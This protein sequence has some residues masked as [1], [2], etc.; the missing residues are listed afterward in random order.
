MKLIFLCCIFLLLA[1]PIFCD[2]ALYEQ[3]TQAVVRIEEHQSVC[4][5]GRDWSIEKN[6]TIGS[7][8][9]IRDRLAGENNQGV[10]RYFIVTARHVVEN[11]GDLFA[12]I[13][14]SPNSNEKAILILPK[15]MWVFHPEPIQ[16]GKFPIDVAVMHIKSNEF[17]KSFLHCD[18]KENPEG[19]GVNQITKKPYKNQVIESPNVIDRGIFFGFPARDVASEKVE[20][21]ARSGIVA[22]TAPQPSLT[23]NGQKV[24]DETIFFIDAPSFGGNSG[25]PLLQEPLPLKGAIKLWGLVS[26]SNIL[27]RDYTLITPVER[28]KETIIH[29]R[30]VAKYNKDCWKTELP[31]LP[32]KCVP[33]K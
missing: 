22:Y 16:K 31:E 12:R 28:I 23:I 20:P 15:D 13:Q 25:G 27:G 18:A 19:C 10:N 21:F 11:R 29:A 3:L 17:I 14:I 5:P 7:A 2:E 26:G 1:T 4:V 33:D 9:F 32:I 6:I 24:Q 8:F 30:S